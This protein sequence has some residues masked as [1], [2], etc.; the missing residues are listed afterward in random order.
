[1]DMR[2][3]VTM[4]EKKR[5]S[6]V[7]QGGRKFNMS[8]GTKISLITVTAAF[9]LAGCASMG[10]LTGKNKGDKAL[11][12]LAT[13]NLMANQIS[14][15]A[16]DKATNKKVKGFATKMNK[17]HSNA[18]K[19]LKQVLKS[20]GMSVPQSLPAGPRKS[21]NKLKRLQ[22]AKYDKKFM[23]VVVPGHQRA[24]DAAKTIAEYSDSKPAQTFAKTMLPKLKNLLAKAKKVRNAV[25]Q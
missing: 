8:K 22:G 25:V 12:R 9:I 17:G 11:K 10:P 14:D 24:V 6:A 1:M 20:Q 2:T 13:I 16:M 21:V 7:E 15:L 5:N 4:Q 19:K 3:T 18:R 23:N